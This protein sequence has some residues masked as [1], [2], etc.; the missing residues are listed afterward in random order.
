MWGKHWERKIAA[1]VVRWTHTH[2]LG[3]HLSS[4]SFSSSSSSSS[5]S[6]LP[7][8]ASI[9]QQPFSGLHRQLSDGRKW[10]EGEKKGR[11]R[12]RRR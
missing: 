6:A 5:S 1:A 7:H 12:R 3:S 2:Q 8:E 9:M 11:R 10:G 4:S